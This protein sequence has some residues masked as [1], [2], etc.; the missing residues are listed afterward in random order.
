MKQRVKLLSLTVAITVSLL[1]LGAILVV[2]GIFDELLKWDIFSSQ[3]EAVLIGV[4]FTSLA[5]SAFGVAMTLVLGIQEIVTSIS[6][7]GRDRGLIEPN[8]IPEAQK[9]TYALYIIGIIGAL[10]VLIGGLSLVDRRVQV[11]RS[12]VFKTI[13]S[14]QLQKLQSRFIQQLVQLQTPPQNNVPRT[15]HDLIQSV[16][17]LSF[18]SQMEVYLPDSQDDTA[19]WSYQPLNYSEQYDPKKGFDRL[20]VAKEYEQAIQEAFQGQP[21]LLKVLND[22][23]G[24]TWYYDIKNPQGKTIAVL[25]ISGDPNED[26]REYKLAD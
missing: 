15:L 11:H 19:I 24:F 17:K 9:Q 26:F 7:F 3:V 5:L 12:Q 10:A 22:R 25:R 21:E 18:V 6:A 14:E 20:V 16:Q 13:A 1:I 23:T 4:F 8:N 2:L